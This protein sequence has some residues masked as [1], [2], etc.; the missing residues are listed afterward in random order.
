IYLERK[1][2]S[3][4]APPPSFSE[5]TYKSTEPNKST[6][7][8]RKNGEIKQAIEFNNLFRFLSIIAPISRHPRQSFAQ[9]KGLGTGKTAYAPSFSPVPP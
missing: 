8:I 4:A 3:P 2:S 9:E 7:R 6:H 1:S 5:R